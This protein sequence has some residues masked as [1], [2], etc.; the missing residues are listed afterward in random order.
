[1]VCLLSFLVTGNLKHF[2][3]SWGYENPDRAPV[4]G[5]TAPGF[6]LPWEWSR[7]LFRLTVAFLYT[8]R[9]ASTTY[10]SLQL[11]VFGS[12]LLQNRNVPVRIFPESQEVLIGG[13]CFGLVTR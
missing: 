8:T 13:F 11:R 4:S 9:S 3:S 7:P 1:M 5:S 6:S 10:H 12:S 2:P